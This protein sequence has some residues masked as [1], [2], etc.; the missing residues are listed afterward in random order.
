MRGR[1]GEKERERKRK[2]KAIISFFARCFFAS[3]SHGF[4]V[5]V[6]VFF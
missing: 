6:F 1:E 3:K 4:A 2:F 5:L